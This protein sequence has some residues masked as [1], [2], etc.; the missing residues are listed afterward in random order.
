MSINTQLKGKIGTVG[1]LLGGRSSEREISL[2]SGTA[3]VNALQ[4]LGISHVAIDLGK[5][6]VVDL[7]KSNIDRA[8]IAL[9]GAGGED[10]RVQAVLEFLNIPYTGSGVQSSAIAMDKLLTKQ[11][12]QGIGIQTPAFKTL[13]KDTDWVAV[14][15]LL[16]GHVMVKPAHEG[17]SI[18][19]ARVST[20]EALRVAY[21]SA[22]QY[23]SSVFAERLMSGDEYTVTILAGTALPVI[24]LETNNEFYDFDAKYISNDTRY[25]CPCGLSQMQESELAQLALKAFNS[26]GCKGWGR[27]DVMADDKGSFNILEV[28]TVPGLTAHSLVPMAAKASGISFNEMVLEILQGSL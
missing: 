19:M 8:F 3:V 4:A 10:G 16:G 27:V 1:V 15:K 5:N 28:N 9:H 23:D 26:L 7:Q 13:D 20:A 22:V 18:G 17:S 12:W 6:S 2:Q 24:K 11:L 14:L 21:E 25:I